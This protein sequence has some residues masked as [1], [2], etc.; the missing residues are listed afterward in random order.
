MKVEAVKYLEIPR[1]REEKLAFLEL[2][3]FVFLPGG[4]V[5]M[6]TNN[7][8]PCRLEGNRRNETP[9][10]ET[11]VLP[12]YICKYK[13]T[14]AVFEIFNPKHVR[15]VQSPD[16]NCPVTDVMY[17]EALTFCSKLNEATGMNFR[18]PIEPEWVFA[19]APFGQE[20]PVSNGPDNALYHTFT[21][22]LDHRAFP[23]DDPRWPVN[24]W[25]LDQ[26]GHNVSEYVFGHYYTLGHSGAETDGM[27]CIVKGGNFGHCQNSPGVHRRGIADVADRNPRL[28]FRLAHDPI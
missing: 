28:G 23:V 13:V 27:Y 14:N 1:S 22:G 8:L 4:R 21:D 12:F 15:P 19:A 9:T 10:R 5:I 2:G 26:M 24:C 3:S 25:G 6:G 17:G 18:L 7:P 11:E 20:Y 16:D